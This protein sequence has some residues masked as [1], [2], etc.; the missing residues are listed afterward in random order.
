MITK[1]IDSC[2]EFEWTP[3]Y[4]QDVSTIEV[5]Q[6]ELTDML[7]LWNNHNK[8]SIPYDQHPTVLVTCDIFAPVVSDSDL[9]DILEVM[10]TCESFMFFVITAA[11]DIKEVDNKIMKSD[12]TSRYLGGGD[13]LVNLNV[14]FIAR[15]R[16]IVVA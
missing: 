2:F 7:N 12:V 15:H 13:Y 14:L 3:L 4:V 5:D 8:H 11:K 9:D 10:C 16:D 1:S 6:N